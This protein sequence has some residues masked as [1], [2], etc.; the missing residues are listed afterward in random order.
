MYMISESDAVCKEYSKMVKNRSNKLVKKWIYFLLGFIVILIILPI[1]PNF[2][3]NE[4]IRIV[5]II[6]GSLILM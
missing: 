4:T 6:Y 5:Y 2:L 1:I 3:D